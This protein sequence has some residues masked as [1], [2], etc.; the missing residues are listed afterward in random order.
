VFVEEQRIVDLQLQ[1][2]VELK[3]EDR[4]EGSEKTAAVVE[5]EMGTWKSV[6]FQ[7]KQRSQLGFAGFVVFVVVVGQVS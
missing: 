4:L 1:G 2:R 5:E 3:I 7:W 6:R